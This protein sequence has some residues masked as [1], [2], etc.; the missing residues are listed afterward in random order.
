MGCSRQIPHAVLVGVLKHE[1]SS[2]T[3]TKNTL[4]YHFLK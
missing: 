3:P 1:E 2:N 4:K